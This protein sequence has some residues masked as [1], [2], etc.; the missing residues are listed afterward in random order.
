MD[1]SALV[2]CRQHDI[3]GIQ[4]QYQ[5]SLYKYVYMYII[6]HLTLPR[7][8]DIV[9]FG[10]AFFSRS[11][12]QTNQTNKQTN[13][14][15]KQTKQTNQTHPDL[16]QKK[17]RLFR[18]HPISIQAWVF[19]PGPHESCAQITKKH[20]PNKKKHLKHIQR[21]WCWNKEIWLRK[22][23]VYQVNLSL[24]NQVIQCVT[25]ASP[26]TLGCHQQQPFEK[27]SLFHH[28]KKGTKNCQGNQDP[29][30][31]LWFFTDSINTMGFNHP[32]P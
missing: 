10:F 13:K 3:A 16:S 8:D 12:R 1:F 32:T 7:S 25:F 27:G 30:F 21:S 2:T 4:Y 5:Y 20:G 15:T 14:Q 17:L 11:N 28:P 29:Y 9:L 6:N 26:E 18:V 24:K 19:S 22:K 23:Y 31:C